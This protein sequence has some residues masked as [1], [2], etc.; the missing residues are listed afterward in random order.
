MSLTVLKAQLSG[1]RQAMEVVASDTTT[2][3]AKWT[4]V[5][6]FV[7]RYIDLASLY[8]SLTEDFKHYKI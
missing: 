3:H 5:N 4:G 6:S 1:M 8:R 7:K 2:D